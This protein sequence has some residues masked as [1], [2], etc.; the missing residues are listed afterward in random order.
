M[1]RK[2]ELLKTLEKLEIEKQTL[3]DWYAQNPT[4]TS[5]LYTT[6]MPQVERH[7]KQIAD[8]LEKLK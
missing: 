4:M 6:R 2:Q 7:I 8:E 3:K 5:H 1:S